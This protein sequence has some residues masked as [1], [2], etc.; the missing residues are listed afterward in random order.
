M[1]DRSGPIPR[2]RRRVSSARSDTRASSE[3]TSPNNARGSLALHTCL[4]VGHEQLR[5]IEERYR[6]Q[7]DPMVVT[8]HR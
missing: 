8:P 5:E 7:N 3:I 6:R 4:A 1:S 2:T